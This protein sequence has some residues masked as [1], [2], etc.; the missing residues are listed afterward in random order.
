MESAVGSLINLRDLRIECARILYKTLHV[1][2]LTHDSETMLWKDKERSRIRTVQMDNLRGLLVIRK[3]DIVQNARIWEF[4][5]VMKEVE[6]KGLMR[7]FSASLVLGRRW[8][9]TGLLR[10]FM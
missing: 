8:R 2:I 6:T 1:P 5:G 7:V 3:I 4:Y 10:E 9:K